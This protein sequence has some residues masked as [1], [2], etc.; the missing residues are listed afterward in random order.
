MRW[1]EKRTP[2]RI[3]MTISAEA[4]RA[5]PWAARQRVMLQ[6]FDVVAQDA[7]SFEVMFDPE[8]D[9]ELEALFLRPQT[10]RGIHT[11]RRCRAGSEPG[12][13]RRFGPWCGCG[14][15]GWHSRYARGMDISHSP[16]CKL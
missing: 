13:T 3:A 16:R 8:A 12:V 7:S 4:E 14:L 10:S 5:L 2:W 1:S 9:P 11:I 15:S 6:V